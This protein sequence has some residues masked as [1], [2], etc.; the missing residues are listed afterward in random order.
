VYLFVP[1]SH[2]PSIKF[3]GDADHESLDAV[4]LSLVI[5]I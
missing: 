2:I 5:L 1:V 4:R 3:E